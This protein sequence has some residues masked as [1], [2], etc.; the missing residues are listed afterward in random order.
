MSTF[1]REEFKWRETYF[2]LFDSCHRPSLKKVERMLHDLNERFELS[3]IRADDDGR[4]E[5]ITVMSTD[6]Y[7][8]LDISY[9][10]G[11][12][13]REQGAVLFE[14]LKSSITDDDERVK[15]QRIPTCDGRFDLLHFEQMTDD[16]SED[17]GDEMLDPSALLIVLD[18]LVELVDGV[19]VDPASGTLL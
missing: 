15:L 12:E 3:N 19:G 10:E 7:A 17:D 1:E 4:F 14:E 6:D 13:V 8:A 16:V 9:M 18:A 5:S 2:V 11:E